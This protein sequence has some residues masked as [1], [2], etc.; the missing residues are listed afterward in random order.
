MP[1]NYRIVHLVILCCFLIGLTVGC[2]SD[3]AIHQ[4]FASQSEQVKDSVQ[5]QKRMFAIVYS[6]A[7][8]LFKEVTK[9]A[10]GASQKLGGQLIVKAPDEGNLEQQ[11]RMMENLIKQHVDGIAISPVDADALTPYIN[12]ASEAGIRVICFDNDAPHSKRLAYIG[13]N[14]YEAGR[15]LAAQLERFMG[16][17]G[18]VIAETGMY[19]FSSIDE[20]VAGFKDYLSRLPDIQLLDIKTNG[21]N[22]DQAIYNLETMI[23]A[24]PHF[25]AYVGLDSLAGSAA[26]LVWKAKGLSQIVLTES[27]LPELLDGVKNEQITAIMSLH[28]GDWGERIINTLNDACDN[29]TIQVQ[30]QMEPFFITRENLKDYQGMQ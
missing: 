21:D 23:E 19:S 2:E 28:E 16:G 17:Q 7:D 4:P 13:I 14:N 3:H 25:D 24:H 22:L 15:K 5:K 6:T 30:N 1:P 8:I 10:E 11:I 12:K 20:R 29:K 27:D 9:K 26:I 18:M